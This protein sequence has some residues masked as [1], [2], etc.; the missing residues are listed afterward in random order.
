MCMVGVSGSWVPRNGGQ[1]SGKGGEGERRG[2]LMALLLPNGWDAPCGRPPRTTP[3]PISLPCFSFS[4]DFIRTL[5]SYRLQGGSCSTTS[6]SAGGWRRR[7]RAASSS[8][9]WVGVL[10]FLSVACTAITHRRSGLSV[11]LPV[12]ATQ[13]AHSI[14]TPPIP[15]KL[16]PG[17]L[18]PGMLPPGS[19]PGISIQRDLMQRWPC[20]HPIGGSEAHVPLRLQKSGGRQVCTPS[21]PADSSTS[22]P[23]LS[24]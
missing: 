4:P 24:P 21:S 7:R 23:R 6:S 2:A 14:C 3:L 1:A 19:F 17:I 22:S 18:S 9:S 5:S 8:P 10:E 15:G 12:V 16:P 20:A 11:G 13:R